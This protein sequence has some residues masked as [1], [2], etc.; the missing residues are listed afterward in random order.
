MRNVILTHK[1]LQFNLFAAVVE[2]L[3]AA[4]LEGRGL[5]ITYGS[6]EDSLNIELWKSATKPEA[7]DG[8]MI[9]QLKISKGENEMNDMRLHVTIRYVKEKC[10]KF[11]EEI[12]PLLHAAR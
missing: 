3:I 4:E 12:T 6:T 5:F 9:H 8:R 1:E 7:G 2:G 11:V 10:M